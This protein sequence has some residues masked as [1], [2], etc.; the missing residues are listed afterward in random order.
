M[1]NLTPRAC[2][3]A[4]FLIAI[5]FYVVRLVHKEISHYRCASKL[6]C[7]P[8]YV[9]PYRWPLALDI[10][11]RYSNAINNQVLQNDDVELFKELGCRP[12]WYQN[13]LGTWHHYTADPKNIQ[14]ILATQF[15][16][17]ELGPLRRGSL[18]PVVGDGIFTHDG[19]AWSHS[20]ALLR[21]QF[22]RGQVANLTLEERHV[23]HLFERL[24]LHSTD[25]WTDP[26]DLAPLFFNLTL[27]SAS[28]FL[29]GE[30][31]NSQITSARTND[32]SQPHSDW[33]DFG[34]A[35][36]RANQA[37][38]NR[39]RLMELY[40]LYS[41]PSFWRDCKI[42]HRFVDHY[43]EQ[44]LHASTS[45]HN[46]EKSTQA[47]S[48]YVFLHELA[49]VTQDK[50]QLRS[51]VLN[52]LIAGRDTTAGLLGWTF[53]LLA[54]HPSIYAKLRS[55]ITHT[56]G[57]DTAD[58]TSTIT[59]ESLKCCTYLQSTLKEVLRLHPLVPENSRRAVH[60]TTLPRGG[61]PDGLSPI[62]IRAGTEVAYN[63]H[64][65]HRRTDLWG[66]DAHKFRPERWEG[67]KGV[68]P[69]WEYL[70]FNGGPRVCLGQQFAL[71]EAG[72]VVVRL[73]QRFDG[74][75]NLDQETVV[76]HKYTNTTS[77]VKCLVRLHE[78]NNE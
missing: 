8:A 25:S 45:T 77:P 47:S 64:I 29:L 76:R 58:N 21:P 14:A 32:A 36:D 27:D 18:G 50:N 37:S 66:A 71:T 54:R 44:A 24:P 16:D 48:D 13:V 26:V 19:K 22:A 60:N 17:F 56:F 3:I 72:Y 40:F 23:Q 7:K 9:R 63:V 74:I 69:G 28:E 6:G 38:V 46:N 41:P 39:G 73:V 1:G 15:N 78:A 2:L 67:E 65:M 55:S 4:A 62:Y 5:A 49:K 33:S 10:L 43:V 75:E 52:I 59:F 42:V 57:T 31:V 61:G 51:E 20:R 35:F 30:S 70:P 53:Y 68:R 12:T 34:S 11:K